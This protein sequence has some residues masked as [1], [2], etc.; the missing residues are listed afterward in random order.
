MLIRSAATAGLFALFTVL[1]VGSIDSE[2]A[3]PRSDTTPVS[4][5]AIT[6]IH[7]TRSGGG[8]L[9]TYEVVER[10]R[11]A[12]G[13][14]DQLVAVV[15]SLSRQTPHVRRAEVIRAIA[16][17]EAD[18]GGPLHEVVM[19]CSH[20]AIRANYSDSYR[21]S[22]PLAMQCVLGSLSQ[23]VY[24]PYDWIPPPGESKR[25]KGRGRKKA[26]SEAL[27]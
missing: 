12:S 4:G 18:I 11:K 13:E 6:P 14:G 24:D 21:A 9:P 3:A 5:S 26:K 8:E 16:E 20:E 23:G 1:A 15:P 2:D 7:T 25:Q 10:M 27:R 19:Y 17:R 22:N